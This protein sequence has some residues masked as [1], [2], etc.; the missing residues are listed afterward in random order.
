MKGNKLVSL[1]LVFSVV[2]FCPLLEGSALEKIR[3]Q[4]RVPDFK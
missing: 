3:K 2:M 1:A 4:A